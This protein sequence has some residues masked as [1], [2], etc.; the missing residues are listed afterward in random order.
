MQY[1]INLETDLRSTFQRHYTTPGTT[2]GVGCIISL[3]VRFQSIDLLYAGVSG[4]NTGC[5]GN[6]QTLTLTDLL[7]P[8]KREPAMSYITL[9]PIEGWNMSSSRALSCT[10][11][12]DGPG[13]RCSPIVKN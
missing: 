10:H 5:L 1:A 3:F 12:S 11:A 4:R 2:Y 7:A 8:R 6:S 9:T 13:L